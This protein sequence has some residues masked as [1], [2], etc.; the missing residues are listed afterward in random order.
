MAQSWNL[1]VYAS[2]GGGIPVIKDGNGYKGVEAVIDKDFSAAKLAE[3][4]GTD[5]LL[6]LTSGGDVYLNYGK[7]DQV[8][9]ETVKVSEMRKYVDEERFAKGSMGPKVEAAVSFVERTGKV[10]TITSLE[11]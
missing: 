11:C 6:I 8:H 9:L 2:G 3:M 7:E 5:E 4:V 1:E 10:A